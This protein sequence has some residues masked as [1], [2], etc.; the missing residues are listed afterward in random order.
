MKIYTV[1]LSPAYDIHAYA[2]ALLL[3]HENLA[4]ITRRDIG[5]KGVNISR[6][7][8]ANGIENVAI[9][10]LGSDGAD[11]FK[12]A[13]ELE[14]VRYRAIEGRGRIREN[15]TLHSDNGTETRISFPG[16]ELDGS[17]LCELSGAIDADADTVVTITGS[18]PAGIRMDRL[19]RL[20]VSLRSSG[21]RIVIDSSSFTLEDLRE[22]RPWLIKP[23]VEEATA[24]CGR[25]LS[26][27]GEYA[28]FAARICAEGIEN[29][30]L[31][32][33]GNGALL[34]NGGDVYVASPPPVVAVSTVGAGDSSIAGAIAALVKNATP[35][36]MLRLAVAYGSAACTL[37]GTSPPVAE[38]ISRIYA[39]VS[40]RAFTQTSKGN[41]RA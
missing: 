22:I 40:V 13:L 15:L 33:G 21:A 9:V 19:K 38:D 4:H 23:N 12:R 14:G 8:T 16:G 20:I 34:A 32:L 41:G 2:P 26:D 29:V 39:D 11:G 24:Y 18:I 25:M 35:S 6:A 27:I 31:T 36:E 28:G 3:G 10:A 7:L 1:T 17:V 37:E 5:G 30:M